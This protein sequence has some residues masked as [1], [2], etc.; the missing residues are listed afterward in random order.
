MRRDD[1]QHTVGAVA[2]SEFLEDEPGLNRL[3]EADIVSDERA[4]TEFLHHPVDRVEL[5]GFEPDQ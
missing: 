5:V 3:P 4:L 2:G 1:E